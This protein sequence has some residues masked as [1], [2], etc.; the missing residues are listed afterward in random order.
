M[1]LQLLTPTSGSIL[2][3]GK[4]IGYDMTN[5]IG[6]LP[7]ERGLHP[8]LTVKEQVL[9]LA[10]LKGMS[11]KEADQALDYWLERFKVTENK[12]KKLKNYQK[13]INK[14]SN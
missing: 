2:Y 3:K 4:K 7:E 6:Y 5:S 1:I 11:R 10:E 8:K 13:E 9:Y 14:K 12:T